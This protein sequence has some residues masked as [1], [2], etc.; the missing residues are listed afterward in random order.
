MVWRGGRGGGGAYASRCCSS[1]MQIVV[2]CKVSFTFWV[3]STHCARVVPQFFQAFLLSFVVVVA[4]SAAL[5]VSSHF[6]RCFDFC[7][8]CAWVRLCLYLYVCTT[9]YLCVWEWVWVCLCELW[10]AY[11]F[12][13]LLFLFLCAESGGYALQFFPIATDFFPLSLC[14]C[15]CVGALVCV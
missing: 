10:L 5:S 1:I 15:V 14:I 6:F 13:L 2:V 11:V 12:F 3:N 4:G 9:Q 8:C 7:C